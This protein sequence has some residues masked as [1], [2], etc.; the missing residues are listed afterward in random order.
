MP[1]GLRTPAAASVGRDVARSLRYGK[2]VVMTGPTSSRSAR[3]QLGSEE[4]T[5][6]LTP[7]MLE[8]YGLD[9]PIAPA[10]WRKF[11]AADSLVDLILEFHT[12]ASPASVRVA[13]LRALR[14]AGLP[15][16]VLVVSPFVAV[17]VDVRG[18]VS[19]V[20]PL[21]NW[22]ALVT[23][24]G[25]LTADDV[26]AEFEDARSNAALRA[27]DGWTI[28][29][30]GRL[31]WIVAQL[32]TPLG[33]VGAGDIAGL[34][35]SAAPAAVSDLSPIKT[36]AENR[37]VRP[38]VLTSRNTVKADAAELLFHV[39]AQELTWAV[40]D[41]GIDAR[42]AAFMTTRGAVPPETHRSRVIRSFDVPRAVEELR[43]IDPTA[44]I[45][46]VDDATWNDFAE[47]ADSMRRPS[48]ATNDPVVRHHGTH[49]AG[50]LAADERPNDI[51]GRE[52]L[53]GVCPSLELV[54]VRV[55]DEHGRSEELWVLVAMRFVRWMNDTGYLRDGRRIDGVNLSLSTVYEVDAQACGWTPVCQ[56]VER[57][58][59]GGIVVVAAAGNQAYDPSVGTASLGTGFR[60]LSITDPGNAESAITVGATDKMSPFRFG[61]IASSGRGP[62]ADGR[63]KPDVLAPGNLVCG[64]SFQEAPQEMTGT[65]Q[66][67]PHVSGIAAMLMAR[68]SELRGQP[69]RVKRLICESATDM[70]RLQDFQG[71]GLVDALRALQRT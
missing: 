6:T 44:F 62:T 53:F 22:F 39:D 8:A 18:L 55:F 59:D 69:R 7:A 42:N 31:R 16:D 23:K 24:L 25:Q 50:I 2:A 26:N 68:F 40:I 64:P 71:S 4:R 20:L 5:G 58:V 21:T 46:L 1:G 70:S 34:F 19:A 63:H 43:D 3:K 66:A 65:S 15:A 17:E 48:V 54:D 49:V 37:V 45:G 12:F 56:E 27:R 28:Q 41:S 61:P 11:V 14:R 33:S 13:L 10:V 52:P 35:A 47:R 57:L 30:L 67:A 36:V 38:A 9:C 60:F 51:V 32:M 29:D